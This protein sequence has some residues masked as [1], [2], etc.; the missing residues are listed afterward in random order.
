MSGRPSSILEVGIDTNSM[1][2]HSLWLASPAFVA[3]LDEIVCDQVKAARC[4]LEEKLRSGLKLITCG[5]ERSLC[6]CLQH[7]SIH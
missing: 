5:G 2:G 7:F 4:Q 3:G 1:Q 6:P